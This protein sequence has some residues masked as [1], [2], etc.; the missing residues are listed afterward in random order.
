MTGMSH[1][2]HRITSDLGPIAA[3]CPVDL[4]VLLS[5]VIPMAPKQGSDKPI[6]KKP[7]PG[8]FLGI[9]S[10]I[11]EVGFI[12]GFFGGFTQKPGCL[13][14]APKKSVSAL[15]LAVFFQAGVIALINVNCTSIQFHV[16]AFVMPSVRL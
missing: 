14:P 4:T 2:N 10:A 9:H 6:F 15:A 13:N 1:Q 11:T 12:D 16:L 5:I 7:N 8:G 3:S